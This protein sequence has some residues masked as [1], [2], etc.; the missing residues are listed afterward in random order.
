MVS[1]LRSAPRSA[2][3]PSVMYAG[4]PTAARPRP[5]RVTGRAVRPSVL[6]EALVT[7]LPSP[8]LPERTSPHQITSGDLDR[9]RQLCGARFRTFGARGGVRGPT[10]GWVQS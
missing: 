7:E 5:I 8:V 6:R 2:A 1:T 10:A 9:Y 4:R 3:R